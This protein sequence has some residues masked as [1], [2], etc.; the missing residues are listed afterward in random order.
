MNT[1]ESVQLK[2]FESLI[3]SDAD[4]RDCIYY[5]CIDDGTLVVFIGGDREASFVKLTLS[6]HWK[7]DIEV[8]RTSDLVVGSRSRNENI[9]TSKTSKLMSDQQNSGGSAK[10][11]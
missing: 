4:L 11:G 5:A 8:Y 6:S 7:G 3:D 2:R 10:F 9:L 1:D